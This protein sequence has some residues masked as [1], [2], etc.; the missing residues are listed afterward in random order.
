MLQVQPEMNYRFGKI[1]YEGPPKQEY[2]SDAVIAPS[3]L[4]GGGLVLPAGR[5]EMLINLFYDVLQNENS[6]YGNRP[7]FN[8]GYNV[9]L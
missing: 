5:G 7:I 2:H 1:I 6:P 8:F 4:M 9:S 3:L